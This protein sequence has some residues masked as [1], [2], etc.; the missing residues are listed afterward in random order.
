MAVAL[1]VVLALV[2]TGVLACQARAFALVL[3][4]RRAQPSRF[5][6]QLIDLVWIAI[7]VAVVLFLAARSWMMAL[8]LGLP[9]VAGVAAEVPVGGEPAPAVQR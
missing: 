9:A 7:P 1:H 3:R 5:R 8:D 6:P 4:S 2:L